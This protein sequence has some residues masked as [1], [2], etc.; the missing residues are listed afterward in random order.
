[1][2]WWF[3]LVR[4]ER[5]L[6]FCKLSFLIVL[7]FLPFFAVLGIYVFINVFVFSVFVYLICYSFNDG[8]LVGV[9]LFCLVFCIIWTISV[10]Q[11][12]RQA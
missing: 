9:V 3:I 12:G 11:L 6:A 2:S 5:V 7:D 8:G 10:C 4:K 1:M